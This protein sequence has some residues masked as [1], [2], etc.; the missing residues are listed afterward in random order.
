ELA[1]WKED[2]RRDFETWL[3]SIDEIPEPGPELADAAN[4]AP[5][6]YS[7]YEQFAAANAESRKANRRTAEAIS[8]WGETLARFEGGLE[9]LRETVVQLTAVQPK[10]GQLSRAHCLMLVELLD[11]MHRLVRAFASPPAA[12]NAWWPFGHDVAWRAHWGAQHQALDILVDHFEGLLQKEGVT[13]IAT[14][15]QPFDP[16]FMLA[17]AAEPDATRPPQTV[18]EELTAGYCRHGELLRAAQVKVSRQS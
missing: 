16:A 4:D 14:I 11:R 15:G 8:Q 18:L 10:V 12:K 2:L 6:L 17:V 7:F 9:P 1:D 13:H 5:D 3:A